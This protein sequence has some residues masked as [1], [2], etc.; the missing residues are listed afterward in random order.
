MSFL[1]RCAP[2]FAAC[3]ERAAKRTSSGQPSA[4]LVRARAAPKRA[5][6]ALDL[7]TVQILEEVVVRVYAVER[8]VCRMRLVQISEEIID[9]M[10]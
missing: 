3:R 8:R 6:L 10:G 5:R 1:V 2:T 7:V 9:E 4:P